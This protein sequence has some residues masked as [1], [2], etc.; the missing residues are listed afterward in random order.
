MREALDTRKRGVN[1]LIYGAP[2]TG[3]SQL[4]RVLARDVG[5]KLFE[6]TSEDAHGEQMSGQERLTA[7]RAAQSFLSRSNSLVAFDEIEDLFSSGVEDFGQARAE[8]VPKAYLNRILEANSVPAFWLSNSIRGLDNAFIRRFDFVFEVPVPPKKHRK[9]IVRDNCADLVDARTIEAVAK[10]EALAPAV[11][12]RTAAVIRSIR[13]NLDERTAGASLELLISNTLEAQRHQRLKPDDPARLPE[14]YDPAFICAD[15]SL[16][17][18]AQG[19][20][21]SRTGRLCLYGPPRTGK[22]AYGRWLADFLDL[23]LNVKRASDLMSP[24]MGQTEINIANAFRKADRAGELLM[25]DEVDSFL[26]DRRSARYAWEIAQV[27]ELLTQLESFGGVFI[28]STNLMVGLD[29]AA[30]RRFDLKVKFDFLESAQ[31]HALFARHCERL[32]LPL[33]GDE[34]R[35][36]FNRIRNLTP[37][38]FATATRQHRF[39]PFRSALNFV[40]ALEAESIMKDASHSSIGFLH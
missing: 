40:A 1:I 17:E 15:A 13:A 36:A 23:T 14:V 28:A 25:I 7:F 12:T 21:D 29:P 11:V 10:A 35:S 20:R 24:Y 38:D 22:T 19:L 4:V 32:A 34:Y 6:V 33:P 8:R 16:D 18:I 27:N 3:K 37:G 2:G 30:L 31:A 9:R 5:C 26:Q 39:R